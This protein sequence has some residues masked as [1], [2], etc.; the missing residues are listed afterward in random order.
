MAPSKKTQGTAAQPIDLTV[1]VNLNRIA[2]G[3][4]TKAKPNKPKSNTNPQ[5]SNGGNSNTASARTPP[6]IA[7]AHAGGNK[8]NDK[9]DNDPNPPTLG[10]ES[11]PA[12]ASC[13]KIKARC[14]RVLA[15]EKCVRRGVACVE[16]ED[17]RNLKGKVEGWN[18]DNGT[19]N[20]K[21]RKT[22]K[23]AGGGGL[24]KSLKTCAGCRAAHTSCV[25]GGKCV[26]CER[27]G[28]ECVVG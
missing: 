20:G 17:K 9:H 21:G 14:D 27:M 11:G 16:A 1:A 13:K 24:A 28:L 23:S 3:R 5:H 18:N 22:G 7:L 19:G 10:K 4:V 6:A 26:R 15:C 8:H 25:R 12:C 2:T